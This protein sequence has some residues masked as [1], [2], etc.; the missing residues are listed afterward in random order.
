MLRRPANWE[1]NQTLMTCLFQKREK[2]LQFN[3]EKD[4]FAF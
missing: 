3:F 4:I 2:Q 1:K